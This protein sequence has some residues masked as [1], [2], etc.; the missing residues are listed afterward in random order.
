MTTLL[1]DTTNTNNGNHHQRQN[2]VS[3][4]QFRNYEKAITK[5]PAIPQFYKENHENQTVEHVMAMK[6]RYCRLDNGW[7][8]VWEALEVMDGLVDNADPDVKTSQAIHALQTAET[9]RRDGQPNWFILTALIHDLGKMLYFMGEPQ[10]TVVGD[11]FPVGCKYADKIVYREFFVNN[12]DFY[13]E[14]YS[15]EYGIY[16]PHCGLRNIHLSFGHDEYMY[17]VCK[18]YLPPEAL[19]ILRFHSF[20]PWHTE[21]E[22]TWLMDDHDKEMLKWVQ[23]FNKYDLGSNLVEEPANLESLKPFYTEL[24]ANYFPPKIRW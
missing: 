21:G 8:S 1:E 10:W 3:Y 12:P 6:E 5:M 24:I 16:T 17:M 22:Y 13:D 18:D 20:Y 9:A 7:F 19:A 15:T 14:L 23:L 4:T 11:T 2:N